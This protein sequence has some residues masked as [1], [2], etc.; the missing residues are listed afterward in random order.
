[1]VDGAIEPAKDQV[2]ESPA[3][4]NSSF[5]LTASNSYDSGL[6]SSILT[7]VKANER[8]P[9]RKQEG[10]RKEISPL[11]GDNKEQHHQ[12]RSRGKLRAKRLKKSVSLYQHIP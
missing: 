5:H 10:K 1:L 4:E 8:K 11:S 9:T 7:W 2:V 12:D 6:P 3:N